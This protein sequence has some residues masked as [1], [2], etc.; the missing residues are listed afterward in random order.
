[1]TANPFPRPL[2]ELFAIGYTPP[3]DL[4]NHLM[5]IISSKPM[6]KSAPTVAEVG[7][8]DVAMAG[9]RRRTIRK[10]NKRKIATAAHPAVGA[11]VVVVI[12]GKIAAATVAI[13]TVQ[14]KIERAGITATIE[15]IGKKQRKMLRPAV[16]ATAAIA[17]LP[18]TVATRAIVEIETEEISHKNNR[19]IATIE[20]ATTIAI[21]AVGSGKE[22]LILNWMESS[23]AREF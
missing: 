19:M 13:T 12:V 6:R 1:M 15:T 3:G 8:P 10:T 5:M 16:V 7:L 18:V 23:K 9:R 20:V 21:P 17:A 2:V 4:L 11:A 22:I 14:P